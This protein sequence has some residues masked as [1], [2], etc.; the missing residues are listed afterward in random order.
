MIWME[1]ATFD[2]LQALKCSLFLRVY[3]TMKLTSKIIMNE[4]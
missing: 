1:C 4:Q 3:R 2:G